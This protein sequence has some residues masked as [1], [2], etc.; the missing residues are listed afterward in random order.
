MMTMR[1]LLLRAA[2]CAAAI[3]CAPDAVGQGRTFEVGGDVVRLRDGERGEQASLR[4]AGANA[5]LPLRAPDHLLRFR[6]ATFDPLQ[7]EPPFAG[8]L[9]APDGTRLWVVQFHTQVLPAYREQLRRAGVEVLAFLPANALTVRV[10][11]DVV[12]ALRERPWVRW[13]GALPNACR[14]DP[15]LHAFVEGGDADDA[16]RDV[17][18]V[19]AQKA[20]RDLLVA[21][22]EALDGVVLHRADGSTMLR[23]RLTAPQLRALLRHDTVVWVDPFDGHGFDMD[24]A[25]VQGGANYVE[26]LGG[27]RGDGV[28]AEIAELFE[29]DHVDFQNVPGRALVRSPAGALSHG[30]CTAGIVGGSGASNPLA[31]GMMDLC[32]IIDGGYYDSA[33]HYSQLQGSVA[34]PWFSMQVTSSWGA[35]ATPSYTAI[36]Q[37]LD[38]ALFEFD[39]VRTQSQSNNGNQDSRPEAWA[40]NGVAVG[41]INHGDNADPSDDSWGGDASIGP[42][43]DGRLKPDIVGYNDAIFTSD[44]TGV[45]GYDPQPSPAGDSM[46]FFSGTS[47]ATPMV[48]GHLGIIQEMFTDGLFGNPLPL[49]ATPQNRFANRPH[50]TTARA[51]LCNTAAQYDFSGAAHDLTRA[52]Q[53]WGFPSLQRLYDHRDDVVVIDEYDVLQLGDATT[54]LVYVAAGTPELR[55]TMVYNDPA[56]SP[57][58]TTQ[59]VN[60]L[61]LLVTRWSDG[62]SWWGNHG[63][64]VG[65]ASTSGGGPDTVDNVEAVYLANPQPGLY[66][67]EVR[68][69]SVVQDAHVET[70]Q[71]DVDYALVMHPMGGGYRTTAG[72]TLELSSTGPGDLTFTP[73]NVPAT[74]WTDGFT[75]LSFD[76]GGARGF[77]DFF[78]LRLDGLSTAIWGVP[79]MAGGLFHFTNAANGYP[80]Q[81][82]TFPSPGLVSAFAGWQL[83]AVVVLLD[84]PQVAGVSNVARLTLQ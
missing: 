48:N 56:G 75:I 35:I 30:H 84:G 49:P 10:D 6:A 54:R 33:A 42:A 71:V 5:W 62:A 78:G 81:P 22:V 67:V 55:V 29:E 8:A 16:A 74:G 83:D 51:L 70:P 36:S 43:Q 15:R 31:R 82:L 80:F 39:V 64:D 44:L 34:S 61:D 23:A 77:G 57:A 2:C 19:L 37:A 72:M 53:G 79:Q 60:D 58:A 73:T 3:A 50:M 46:S 21:Q 52:H 59:L 65:T 13:A 40:K 24:N 28:R 20:D 25:R 4:R 11:A 9:A 27:Y 69:A 14:L 76:A 41:A 12:A 18:L 63:L 17:H 32:T 45:F 38:D 66:L 47:G 7:T 68:A 1:S 26:A